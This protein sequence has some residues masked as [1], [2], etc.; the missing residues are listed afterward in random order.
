MVLSMLVFFF[1]GDKFGC[2]SFSAVLEAKE[3][4]GVC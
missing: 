3:A 2:W 4:Y 1:G